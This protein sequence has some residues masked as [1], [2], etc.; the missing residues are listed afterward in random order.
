MDKINVRGETPIT[1][2]QIKYLYNI[3]NQD[4][5]EIRLTVKAMLNSKSCCAIEGVLDCI[6][7]IHMTRKG[8]RFQLTPGNTDEPETRHK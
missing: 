5:R 6:G 4:H 7:L 2:R 8:S 1:V 3:V